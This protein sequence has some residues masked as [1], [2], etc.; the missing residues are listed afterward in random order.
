[1][2]AF[3]A[4]LALS[5]SMVGGAATSR[6]WSPDYAKAFGSAK[7]S[8]R[9]LLVVLEK[10]QEPSA[11]VKQASFTTDDTMNALLGPYEL[12]RVDVSSPYGRK[13]AA[14]FGATRFPFTAI[15]DR[16]CTVLVYK[17]TG[18]FT[19]QEWVA[20]LVAYQRGDRPAMT[21]GTM[22]PGMMF[23]EAVTCF[24]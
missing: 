2:S 19:T 6:E 12:C 15:T 17:K 8:Q 3:V 23:P 11:Q 13:V 10:P 16:S 20:M 18:R 24:T 9:P 21:P 1:M 7:A 5:M 14:A 22:T 4:T